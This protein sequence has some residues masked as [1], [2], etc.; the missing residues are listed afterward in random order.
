MKEEEEI[1]KYIIRHR[2]HSKGWTRGRRFRKK[3]NKE[4]NRKRKCERE[5]RDLKTETDNTTWSALSI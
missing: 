3:G 2:R 1:S 5:N 4:T